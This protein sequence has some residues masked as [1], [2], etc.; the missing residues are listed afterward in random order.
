MNPKPNSNLR[1]VLLRFILG[2]FFCGIVFLMGTV[3]LRY[4][5]SPEY[6]TIESGPVKGDVLVV[7]GGAIDRADRALKLYEANEAPKIL[8]TGTGDWVHNFNFLKNHGVL[9]DQ[10]VIEKFS[11][12]TRNNARFSVPRLREMN[13]HRVIL[14]TSWYHSRRALACFKH[15]APEL[16]F[17]SRPSYRCWGDT[18]GQWS[19]EEKRNRKLESLKYFWYLFRYGI[20]SF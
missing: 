9:A 2:C 20:W 3:F 11:N 13:A 15:E 18:A 1:L 6:Q 12:N 16:E 14:V 4:L 17:F 10:I 5:N 19:K 8:L 7:L